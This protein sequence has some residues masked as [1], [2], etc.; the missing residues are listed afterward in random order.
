MKKRKRSLALALVIAFQ[1]VFSG[2]G[3]GIAFAASTGT[4]IDNADGKQTT[5]GEWTT[6]SAADCY[7]DDYSRSSDGTVTIQPT[8][9]QTGNYKIYLRWPK[10]GDV[11]ENLEI[12]VKDGAGEKFSV[13][14]D[15]TINSGYW[16][17]VGT[18]YFT[19]GGSQT[20]TMKAGDS[21]PIV[22]DAMMVD[23]SAAVTSKAPRTLYEG[24]SEES[25]GN[26]DSKETVTAFDASKSARKLYASLPRITSL[27]NE[28]V[29][30]DAPVE[31]PVEVGD[32]FIYDTSSPEFSTSGGSWVTEQSDEA[33][34]GK[35]MSDGDIG[36]A[37]LQFAKWS[38]KVKVH[39]HYEVY[40]RWPGG[41]DRPDS[42]KVIV[43]NFEKKDSSHVVDQTKDSGQWNLIGEYEFKEGVNSIIL[44]ANA[45]GYTAADAVKIKLVSTD[46]LTEGTSNSSMY[47]ELKNYRGEKPD[48][49]NIVMDDNQHFYL[50]RNGEV[51]DVHGACYDYRSKLE[52]ILPV[53]KEAGGNMIRIYGSD[54]LY[55]GVLDLCYELGITCMVQIWVERT[56]SMNY[57]DPARYLEHLTY[58]KKVI[59]DFKDH[60]SIAMWCVNNEAEVSDQGGEVYT[61]T[62]ELARY[63]KE[64]DPYHP[65]A[66]MFAGCGTTPQTNLMTLMP[67]IDI[68]GVNV[69]EAVNQVYDNTMKAGWNGPV[70]VGEFGPDGTW[71][72][73]RTDWGAV[74]E[75]PNGEK[76]DLYRTRYLTDILGNTKGIGGFAFCM[77]NAV[78][79][80]GT[81]T[82]Y[83]FLIDGMET[84]VMHEMRYAWTGKYAANVAPRISKFTI[85]GKEPADGLVVAPGEEMTVSLSASDK[86]S[87]ALS[88]SVDV[89][90]EIR[91]TVT[92]REPLTFSSA[93][94]TSNP[95]SIK[96]KA[97]DV[98]G[99]YRVYAKVTDGHNN[100]C[101]DNFPIYVKQTSGK[102]ASD[103]NDPELIKTVLEKASDEFT[104]G[105]FMK[106]NVG[107]QINEIVNGMVYDSTGSAVIEADGKTNYIT[108]TVNY[109]SSDG[110]QDAEV[111]F[112]KTK[113]RV[114][115]DGGAWTDGEISEYYDLL[116][117]YKDIAS[118]NS[119]LKDMTIDNTSDNKYIIIKS[120]S[121][122]PGFY[123]DSLMAFD[124]GSFHKYSEL[125]D[126]HS[127]TIY[128]S[129]E[130]GRVVKTM[131][132]FG[133]TLSKEEAKY[134]TMKYTYEYVYGDKTDIKMP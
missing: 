69:Y 118:D 17:L 42:A 92:A 43:E 45:R 5:S 72:V 4:I 128:V 86:E 35:Y 63:I 48:R 46:N 108:S 76:G 32:E 94:D 14:R 88:Y 6:A 7:G 59:D 129:K 130:T 9:S 117:T 56:D 10:L 112:N 105:G 96:V 27:K 62:E 8:V 13:L 113:A 74:I 79:A 57:S 106:A 83:A 122:V 84:P 77:A 11:T 44:Q 36:D 52:D 125:T 65:V 111:Y 80:E 37:Y 53:F 70:V 110:T 85:N 123:H 71:E 101:M 120:K 47:S 55:Q 66:T 19:S 102:P 26:A 21:K 100:V 39:G 2:I 49:Y 68:L 89:K 64:V 97:P 103:I 61:M 16:V 119:L 81:E 121:F 99:W 107:I 82:W 132:E 22:F 127:L 1:T 50:T 40:L 126:K 91:L 115:T 58:W 33:L 29:K 25:I 18:Y 15:Q 23:L 114:K 93:Q 24:L 51:L 38:P 41:N 54:A 3:G 95:D 116:N 60:P 78:G 87:D 20:I 90:E 131:A 31:K 34:K 133:Y 28:V 75:Q 67:S 30:E 104:S 12:T 98:P 124:S 73:D 109:T 134:R